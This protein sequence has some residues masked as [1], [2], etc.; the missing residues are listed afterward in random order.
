MLISLPVVKKHKT[1]FKIEGWY[2]G[3]PKIIKF[4][5]FTTGSDI[6][7]FPKLPYFFLKMLK[8]PRCHLGFEA[9]PVKKSTVI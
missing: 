1:F 9:F 2:V 5:F 6:N 8:M 4:H 3:F 7:I